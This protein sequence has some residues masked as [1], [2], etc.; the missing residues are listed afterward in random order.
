[1][2]GLNN[3]SGNSCRQ[4]P[5][6]SPRL[7]PR[8]RWRS[9]APLALFLDLD[10]V[11]APMAP[12]PDAVVADATADGRADPAGPRAGRSP[13]DRQRPDPDRD[14]PHLRRGVALC[15][16]RARAGTAAARRVGGPARGLA[17]RAQALDAFRRLRRR[18]PRRDR[19]G[20]GASRRACTIVRRPP[21]PTRRWSWRATW[22]RTTGL[23]LQPGHMVVELQHARRRQGLGRRR[24]HGRAAVRRAPLPVML[25]DDLTDEAGFARGGRPGRLRRAGRAA[26]RDRRQ[27]RP[28]RRRQR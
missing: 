22:P 8:P 25:G 18:P 1:M 28:A 24:L 26:S 17:R 2:R 12:T 9:D 7:C 23:T 4:T 19:R 13:G 6:R 3:T 15:R 20:Q 10:G 14:R 11:L 5:E 21:W 16:R 27:L